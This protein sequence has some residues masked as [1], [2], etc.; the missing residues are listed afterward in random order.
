MQLHN[1]Q[2]G[3]NI[4]PR[5]W[6]GTTDDSPADCLP[7]SRHVLLPARLEKYMQWHTKLGLTAYML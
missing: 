4:L 6:E 5:S 2:A 3:N 1:P 7:G